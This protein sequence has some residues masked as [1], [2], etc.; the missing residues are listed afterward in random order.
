MLRHK[1]VLFDKSAF[2]ALPRDAHASWRFMFVETLPPCL[3]REILADLAKEV[4][5]NNTAENLV[6]GLAEK[7]HGGG[8]HVNLDWQFLCIGS[9]EGQPVEMRGYAAMLEPPVHMV[10][11]EPTYLVEP[12]AENHAVIRWASGAFSRGERAYAEQLRADVKAFESNT[13]YGRVSNAPA[14]KNLNTLSADVDAFIA[15][16][17]ALVIDWVIDQLRAYAHTNNGSLPKHRRLVRR[18]WEEAERP[19]LKDLAPYAHHVARTLLML[20]LGRHTLPSNPTNRRQDAEYLLYLPFCHMFVSDDRLH[21]EL[22][23]LLLFPYQEVLTRHGFLE[24][25]AEAD[26]EMGRST[27]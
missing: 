20:V 6:R 22:A 12:S 17:P 25:I 16:N 21:Q 14:S 8:G 9:L 23:P 24:R 3:L 27:S 2:Q 11:G 13:F 5:G 18:R 26:A 7:F 4:T 1:G 19:H 15:E 10:N